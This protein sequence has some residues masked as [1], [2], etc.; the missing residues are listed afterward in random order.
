MPFLSDTN[1]ILFT[2]TPSR[3]QGDAAVLRQSDNQIID[4]RGIIT[5]YEIVTTFRSFQRI[6]LKG[7]VW[8]EVEPYH[9][10]CEIELHTDEITYMWNCDLTVY[11]RFISIR[12]DIL[13]LSE[14]MNYGFFRIKQ[15][16]FDGGKVNGKIVDRCR[17]D[18]D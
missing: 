9:M 17:K 7:Y 3:T 6:L 4:Y 12:Y 16:E 10:E 13:F 2:D 8:F 5:R 15:L 1:L 18:Y 14:F 11:R